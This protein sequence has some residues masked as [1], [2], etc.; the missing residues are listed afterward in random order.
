MK[1]EL[2]AYL[3]ALILGVVVGWIL[4]SIGY[5]SL[6]DKASILGAQLLQNQQQSEILKNELASS[7]NSYKELHE[8]YDINRVK[9]NEDNVVLQEELLQ[10]T[11]KLAETDALLLSGQPVVHALKLKLIEANNTIVR[12]KS[13]L[14]NGDGQSV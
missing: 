6:K 2:V 12:Y 14:A 5:R 10:L 4:R 11:A 8:S 13:K 3:L 1:T 9:A 7:E